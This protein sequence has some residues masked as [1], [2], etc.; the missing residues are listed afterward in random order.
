MQMRL[1]IFSLAMC[2]IVSLS[3]YSQNFSL[4]GRINDTTVRV[5]LPDASIVL[6]RQ[7]DS[8][9]VRWTWTDSSGKFSIP[10]MAPGKYILLVSYPGYAHYVDT[11]TVRE[12]IDLGTISVSSR[13]VILQEV[14]VGQRISA[15]RIK[16]DTTEYA[17]NSF[18]VHANASVEDL[19]K[20]L[21]GIQVDRL[22]NITAQGQKVKRVLVDGEEFFGSDPT[23]VTQNLTADMVEKVQ[24]FDK[25]SDQSAFTGINDG[26]KDKTI[27]VKLKASKKSGI[28]G[29][30]S[31]AAGADGYYEEQ[32][33]IN[34]FADKLKA[35]A[36]GLSSNTGV[37]GLAFKDQQ[38]YGDAGASGARIGEGG[39][40]YISISNDDDGI[41][42]WSGA[43]T[44]RGFPSVHTGG[45]HF[46]NKWH[47]DKNAVNANYKL[48]A[49]NI[50]GKSDGEFV[51]RV[52]G[53]Y[54][55]GSQTEK[56]NGRS[57]RNNFNAAYEIQ[58]SSTS[59][60]KITAD[61]SASEKEY[62]TLSAGGLRSSDNAF[63]N[64]SDKNTTGH[65]EDQFFSGGVLWRK[66]FKKIGRTFSLNVRNNYNS[67][68]SNGYLFTRVHFAGSST[69]DSTDQY[70]ET[71]GTVSNIDA[72]LT[73]TEPISKATSIVF[74][75]GI[76][77]N[78][79]KS[80]RNSFEKASGGHT[81]TI[82][83]I[84]NSNDYGYRQLAHRP[85]ITVNYSRLKWLVNAGSSV[86]FTEYRQEDHYSNTLL[87]RHFVNLNPRA[88]ARYSV[89]AQTQVS[90]E[91]SGS[92][93]QPSIQQLQPVQV[94]DDPLNTFIGSPNL[95]PAFRSNYRLSF[96]DNK[97]VSQRFIT[98]SLGYSS[99]ANAIISNVET[100]LTTGLSTISYINA[101]GARS[102]SAHISYDFTIQKPDINLS[103][104]ADGNFSRYAMQVNKVRV[105]N[106]SASYVVGIYAGKTKENKYD[107]RIDLSSGYYT[108]ATDFRNISTV[109]YRTYSVHP[110]INV[111]MKGKIRMQTDLDYTIRRGTKFFTEDISRVL[112]SASI[113]K[114]MLKKENLQLK[115]SLTD[116]LNQNVSIDRNIIGSTLSQT[117][118]EIPARIFLITAT[119]NFNRQIQ[120]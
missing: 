72:R 77:F 76:A 69:S 113:T 101:D 56:Y 43:Y 68:E 80:T 86:A 25:K 104:I 13:V 98:G 55:F 41:N 35:A 78:D 120:K 48:L 91:Y 1:K 47:Q 65:S 31:G 118:S 23:L 108:A 105:D 117:L 7:Q 44:G 34:K 50:G 111:F 2:I 11:L 40:L 26:V 5:F 30:I 93:V 115:L 87:D 6:L 99:T 110:L 28:F 59:S 94:N 75:Y 19:L 37:A 24:V 18:K 119:W 4:S 67:L 32:G 112:W 100:D 61:G 58:L 83:N 21:P 81:Y 14:V 10:G 82:L 109:S 15:I 84:E 39:G 42:S 71:Y 53:D 29:K 27:N 64:R 73:Y 17:A 54:T 45:A 96:T 46:S 90:V 114:K 51:N 9:L 38:S 20:R 60:V 89:S 57:V 92:T 33:M 85:G 52:P 95:R 88:T 62:T 12:R 49:L 116:I 102:A 36:Y 106:N 66:K 3:T 8:M 70:K 74:N 63:L 107:V 103:V 97:D 79:A 16:G 22:G